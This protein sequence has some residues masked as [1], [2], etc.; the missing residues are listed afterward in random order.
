MEIG[1]WLIVIRGHNLAPLFQSIEEQ[2]LMRIRA[3]PGLAEDISRETDTFATE[4]RFLKAVVRTG[5]QGP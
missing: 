4:I 5:R 2:T 3:L 1:D